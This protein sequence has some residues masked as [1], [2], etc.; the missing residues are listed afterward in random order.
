MHALAARLLGPRLAALLFEFLR[1]G[2]V[3][4]LGFLVDNATVYGSRA[5]IGLYWG[6]AL[7][8]LTAATTTWLV[9]RLWTFRGRGTGPAHRQ[10]ALFLAVNLIGFI[11]N[12]GTYAVLITF[13]QTAA[14]NPVI[15][16]F[17]GTLMGMFLNFHFSRTVV[18]R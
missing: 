4:F 2:T 12:R 7:A 16:I 6:G 9:N 13:S 18:F 15:A 3:G 1:F 8:Y 14:N 10:W 5:A 17:A 11:L